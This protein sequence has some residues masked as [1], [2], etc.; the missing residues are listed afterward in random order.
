LRFDFDPV[1]EWST[2]E[3]RVKT[4]DDEIRLRPGAYAAARVAEAAVPLGNDRSIQFQISLW[5]DGIPV[6][7]LPVDGWLRVE[8][9]VANWRV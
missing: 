9:P 8:I 1:P 3:I 6:E 7:S 2:L 4:A 5:L